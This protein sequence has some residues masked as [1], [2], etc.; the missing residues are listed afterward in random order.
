M[1]AIEAIFLDR[2]GTIGGDDTVHY[3]GSF[4]LFPFTVDMIQKLKNDG[5]KVFS[6]TNQPGIANKEA[7]EE[8]FYEELKGFGFNDVFLCPHKPEDRC[9]CRKP[10]AGMLLKCADMYS[11]KL[12]QCVVIGDRWSDMAAA[13]KTESIKILVKTGAG[14]NTLLEHS[15]KVGD[16]DFIAEDLKEAI[17][18]L[19]RKYRLEQ[20]LR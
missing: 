19:Y 13:S 20:V 5:I 15:N 6:F 4:K 14:N 12:D 2:D 10:E 3:P 9:P 1:K 16:V 17:E 18:W 11:L 8:S 7:S